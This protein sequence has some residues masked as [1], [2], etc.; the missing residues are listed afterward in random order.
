MLK[1]ILTSLKQ[2]LNQDTM[3]DCPMAMWSK[4]SPLTA[5]CLSPLPGFEFQPGHEKVATDLGLGV[6]C[7]C[8]VIQFPPLVTTG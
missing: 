6:A 2:N 4:A 8:Q 3:H 7:F 1:S 5:S